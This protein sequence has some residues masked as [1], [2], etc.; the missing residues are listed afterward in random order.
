MSVV[1]SLLRAIDRAD[2]EALVMHVGEKPY[3]VTASGH[4]ELAANALTFPAMT[5]MLD[6]L[7]PADSR[8]ALNELGAVEY[9]LPV[10]QCT[11]GARYS[12]VAARGG[13]D[14]WIEVRRRKE[15]EEPPPIPVPQAAGAAEASSPPVLEAPSPRAME[16]DEPRRPIEEPQPVAVEEP[17][18]VAYESPDLSSIE[19]TM[20]VTLAPREPV[21]ALERLAVDAPIHPEAPIVDEPAP[22]VTLAPAPVLRVDESRAVERFGTL[23]HGEGIPQSSEEP[24]AAVPELVEEPGDRFELRTPT[25]VDLSA[26][27]VEEDLDEEPRHLDEPPAPAFDFTVEPEPMPV[28]AV[29]VPLARVNVRLEPPSPPPVLSKPT[30][31]PVDPLRNLLRVAAAQGASALYVAPQARPSVR[32]DGEMRMLDDAPITDAQ[33]EAELR[34]LVPGAQSDAVLPG[35]FETRELAG[36]GRVQVLLFRDHRG[37]GAIFRMLPGRTVSAEQAGLSPGIQTLCAEPEGLLL[38]AGPHGAGKSTLVAAVVDQINRTR[39]DHVI[40]IESDIQ[41][42]HEN[43]VSF[44]S[45]REAREDASFLDA[46]RSAIREAPDVLVIDGVMNAEVAAV[47]LQAA[48]DGLVVASVPAPATA[49]ALE[50]FIGFFESDTGT[51]RTLVSEHLRGVVTQ[52]LVRKTGGGR[53]AAR[54]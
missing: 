52:T 2:G 17:D 22:P 13:D 10:D 5:G 33:L 9:H 28:A 44:V 48:A 18:F 45:Q 53:A 15:I 49:A 41:F 47:A 26:G 40:T 12:V 14:I 50:R 42:V 25:E 3:V 23:P 34:A 36:V 19:G 20:P 39:R 38:V 4:A 37:L 43:R 21:E 51:A 46:V 29:V 6:Q 35:E 8:R 11:P 54:E 32:V 7:L 27:S 30:A 16:D 24:P 31:P 1:V